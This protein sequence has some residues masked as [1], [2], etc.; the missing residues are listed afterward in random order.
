MGIGL[1]YDLLGVADPSGHG[2]LAHALGKE[3]GHAGMAEPMHFHVGEP[4][5]CEVFVDAPP[6]P[7]VADDRITGRLNDVCLGI[8]KF[9]KTHPG[10]R[11]DEITLGME[12]SSALK[13]RTPFTTKSSGIS[14]IIWNSKGRRSQ[15]DTI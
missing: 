10:A 13:R 7:A 4:G 11:I 2:P 14:A 6:D 3:I 5:F 12:T 9:V 8:L 15:V 1:Q